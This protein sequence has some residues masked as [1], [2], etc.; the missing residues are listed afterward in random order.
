[1]QTNVPP[2]VDSLDE[3]KNNSFTNH[4]ASIEAVK[5]ATRQRDKAEDQVKALQA[6]VVKLKEE[7]KIAT[8]PV[9]ELKS[10]KTVLEE[11]QGLV[12]GD[13]RND[14]NHP[15]Y[16][17]KQT[18]EL[19][20]A[21]GFNY[22]NKS[23]EPENVA[24]AMVLVKMSRESFKHKVDNLVDEAGYILCHS[25]VLEKKEEIEKDKITNS[26]ASEDED[27]FSQQDIEDYES[28]T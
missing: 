20:T 7:L 17:F 27:T 9:T 25:L 4:P 2:T 10:T 5:A 12:L 15:Y 8:T 1:M 6:E 11:A 28:L 19:W 13:R 24:E 3:L 23:V 26:E 16:N 14:Y 22:K 18:A 21:L